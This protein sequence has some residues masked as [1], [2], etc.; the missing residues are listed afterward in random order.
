MRGGGSE[1]GKLDARVGP[2]PPN[3]KVIWRKGMRFVL[4]HRWGFRRFFG[5]R[6]GS[7][8]GSSRVVLVEVREALEGL[9]QKGRLRKTRHDRTKIARDAFRL[10]RPP[11]SSIGVFD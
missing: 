10:G 7:W 4:V 1:A 5:T 3:T 6:S 9:A 8:F 11:G 2:A